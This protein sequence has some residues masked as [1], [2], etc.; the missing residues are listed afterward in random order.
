MPC[1][2]GSVSNQP[3][4]QKTL[5]ILMLGDSGVGKSSFANLFLGNESCQTS[6]NPDPCTLNPVEKF[7]HVDGVK[8]IVV[9][10]E[11][12]EDGLNIPKDQIAKL[13][14]MM[15]DYEGGIHAIAITLYGDHPRFSGHEKNIVKFAI[16]AFGMEYL[17]QFCIIF[18]HCTENEPNREKRNTNYREALNKYIKE[19]LIK[20]GIKEEDIEIPRIPMFFFDCKNKLLPFVR[21]ELEHFIDWVS[22]QSLASTQNMKEASLGETRKL[23]Q[24]SNVPLEK[25]FKGENYYQKVVSRERYMIIPNNNNDPTFTDWVITEETCKMLIEVT[26]EQKKN[27]LHSYFYED[28]GRK[29]YKRIVDLERKVRRNCE[30]G[31][32]TYENWYEIDSHNELIAEAKTTTEQKWETIVEPYGKG[33]KRYQVRLE[34]TV[35][36][37][38]DGGQSTGEWRQVSGESNVE[39]KENKKNGFWKG[40]AIGTASVI[41]IGLI[42]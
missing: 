28:N 26:K 29:K 7:S 5:A 37:L 36:T 30:T 12:F 17:K 40:L 25:F 27:Q 39:I 2:N 8:R 31:E 24:E 20:S 34:R 38:P 4:K 23:I 33:Y 35:V 15:K 16:D 1:D 41:G 22:A 19:E 32:K 42:V 14:N 18:T 13:V 11:G 3:P 10:T 6:D 21:T 9:D